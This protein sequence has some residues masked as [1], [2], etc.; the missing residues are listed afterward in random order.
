EVG[1]ASELTRAF[2]RAAEAAG[3][4]TT[5]KHF[6]G[7]G[8]TATDSHDSL[9]RVDRSRGE[10]ETCELVPFQAAVDAGCSLVMTAHVSYPALDPSDA[11]ATFSAIMLQELLR[12]KMG[13]RGIICSDSLLMAG[14]RERFASEEEMALAV[15]N[16]GVDLLLDL[17][18]PGKVVD[19]LCEC[20]AAGRLDEKRVDEAA[21][22]VAALKQRVFGKSASDTNGTTDSRASAEGESLAER[23][24][25]GAIEIL[26]D[27]GHNALPFQR[28]EPVLAILL[29][30]FETPIEPLEQPLAR[31]L[32]ER[33]RDV[34]YVQLGPK[35]DASAYE[36]AIELLRGAKQ[37]LIA[38][39]V[40]PAAWYAF[41][42]QDEQSAFVR[43]V[44]SDRNDVVLASL[45]VP[46][47]LSDYPRAGVRICT[48]S[49]VPA[50]QRALAEFLLN[51]SNPSGADL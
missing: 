38:V 32:R 35:A 34:K 47:V 27:H 21:A 4:C 30:P 17:S 23:V 37:L 11:P 25:A 33:F 6:P 51:L 42:L 46:Y 8:S 29:K 45:G 48:Y 43:Q 1:R 12:D 13:F 26:K 10:L 20:V 2:V 36:S 9:P 19:F 28:E 44:T 40:R 49:D 31:E 5:A 7:H 24:A 50:S 15:L 41:G 3:L 18:E 39:I 22:R 16:A 14:A